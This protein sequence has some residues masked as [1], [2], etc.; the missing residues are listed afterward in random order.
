MPI[1]SFSGGTSGE[2]LVQLDDKIPATFHKAVLFP[3]S[4]VGFGFKL[5]KWGMDEESV[6]TSIG[7]LV[8]MWAG[9]GFVGQI[10]DGAEHL[11]LS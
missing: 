5:S 8:V 1:V 2:D 11:L 4:M 6:A 10:F 3:L 9:S 7:A